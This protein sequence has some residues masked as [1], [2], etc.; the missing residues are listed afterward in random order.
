MQ[1]AKGAILKELDNLPEN[2]WLE[3]DVRNIT[4]V[5]QRLP[6]IRYRFFNVG[7]VLVESAGSAGSE[8]VFRMQ[9]PLV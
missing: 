3:L 7:D 2:S 4:H 9:L 8:V 5:K 1:A 6:W